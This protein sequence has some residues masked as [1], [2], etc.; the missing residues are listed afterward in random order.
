VTFITNRNEELFY[1]L[2]NFLQ[3]NGHVVPPE[4][5]DH[6]ATK[7]KPGTMEV[8]PRRKQVIFAQ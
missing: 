1:D 7:I 3:Q 4:L 2:K 8:V 5:A 6:P